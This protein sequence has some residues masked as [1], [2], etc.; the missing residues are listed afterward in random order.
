MRIKALMLGEHCTIRL[1]A[2]RED[3]RTTDLTVESP[4]M[5]AGLPTGIT[6][7]LTSWLPD[8][9]ERWRLLHR[10][11]SKGARVQCRFAATKTVYTFVAAVHQLTKAKNKSGE[12][13]TQLGILIKGQVYEKPRPRKKGK[14]RAVL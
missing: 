14:K 6:E 3:P 12:S 10:W 7:V 8:D 2:E 11:W 4:C 5:I 13:V 9:P 1:V